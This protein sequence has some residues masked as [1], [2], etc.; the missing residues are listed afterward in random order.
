MVNENKQVTTKLKR[1]PLNVMAIQNK[2]SELFKSM[3]IDEKR[4]LIITS[5]RARLMTGGEEEAIY[6][7]AVAY[8]QM[9]SILP[10]SAYKQLEV[11]IKNLVNRSFSYINENGKKV[12]SNWVIEAVYEEGGVHMRF[13]KIVLEMLR[14][15]DKNNP[16][17]KYE[18]DIVLKL[19]KDYSID[20]YHWFKR[21]QPTGT[22]KISIEDLFKELDLPDSYKDLSN[23]KRRVI[24]SSLKEINEKTDIKVKYETVKKGRSVQ[25]FIFRIT[26]NENK[27]NKISL[28][29]ERCGKDLNQTALRVTSEWDMQ[30]KVMLNELGA[31]YTTE[32]FENLSRLSNKTIKDL[33]SAEWRKKYPVK[34][35]EFWIP[36]IDK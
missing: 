10:S 15:L 3:S 9:C 18:T 24:E 2:P 35:H 28:K 12:L 5:P 17:T 16:Y 14:V 21:W 6:I 1:Y 27:A 36:V 33:V 29:K 23:L 30:S 20:F 32:Y 25:S 34:D 26:T 31:E 8:G 22:F 4:L 11:A 13:P 7:S 19:K